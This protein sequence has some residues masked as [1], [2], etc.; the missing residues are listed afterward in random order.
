MHAP[1]C[2]H[3][4][5]DMHKH[6]HTPKGDELLSGWDLTQP[7]VEVGHMG[8]TGHQGNNTAVALPF[9][10]PVPLSHCHCL[11]SQP[12]ASVTLDVL[13]LYI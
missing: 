9:F 13:F 11:L 3:K 10:L 6:T 1:S 2:L 12:S 5:T 8:K 4:Y 7:I